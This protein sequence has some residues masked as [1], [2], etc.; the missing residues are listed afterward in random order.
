MANGANAA[1]V[2]VNYT[3]S[4]EVQ[5]P[6][7]IEEAYAATNYIVD[8]ATSLN[9]DSSKL[10]VGGD[11]VGGNM[12]TVVTMLA[13]ERK[14]PNILFQLLFYSVTNA[15]FNTQSYIEFANGPLL[16]RTLMMHFWDWYLPNKCLRNLPTASPLR[17]SLKQ[18]R[19]LPPALIINAENDV[20]ACDGELYACKLK[21]AGVPTRGIRIA[22]TIHDF[23]FLN[24]LACTPATMLAISIAQ[25]TLKKVF[26]T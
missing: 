25:A 8:N 12:A 5:Y 14:G 10:A 20:L 3:R 7:A 6:V 18:L 13:K 15:Y 17:A 24:A 23:V 16:T 2:F 9:L 22:G 1:L 21:Q 11:S 26:G 19:G 4:P